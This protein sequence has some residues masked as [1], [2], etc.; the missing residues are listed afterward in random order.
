M[1]RS[2]AGSARRSRPSW[3]CARPQPGELSAIADALTVLAA[4]DQPPPARPDRA[5]AFWK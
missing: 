1:A 3:R 4:E 5:L 2:T